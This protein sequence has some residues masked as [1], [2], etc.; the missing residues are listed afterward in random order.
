MVAQAGCAA[1][2]CDGEVIPGVVGVTDPFVTG[3]AVSALV[4]RDFFDPWG[5]TGA[6][7]VLGVAG[8]GPPFMDQKYEMHS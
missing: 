8:I 7:R 4:K 3:T 2:L 1:P 6:F 5:D